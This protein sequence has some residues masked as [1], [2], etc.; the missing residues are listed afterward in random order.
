MTGTGSASGPPTHINIAGNL[1]TVTVPNTF[2]VGTEAKFLNLNAATYL[3]NT[4]VIVASASSTQFTAKFVHANDD[5]AIS[6]GSV[7]G[8]VCTN[9]QKWVRSCGTEVFDGTPGNEYAFRGPASS[10]LAHQDL[11]YDVNGEPVF[12][13]M[14]TQ[15]GDTKDYRALEITDLST[16]TPTA[17][18]SKRILMPCS[19]DYIGASCDSGVFV[20][21]DKDQG[22]ISLQGTSGPLKGY[23][24]LS[25][26]SMAGPAQG[27]DVLFPPKTTLGADVASA[28]T[29]TVA[30]VSMTQVGSGVAS[31][32]GFGTANAEVVNWMATTAAT[33]T[34]TFTKPHSASE[35]VSC[36]SCGS[37]GWAAMELL[38]IKID[39]TAVDNSNAVF[40]RIGRTHGIRDGN[41]N[42]EAHATVNRDFTQMIWGSSWDRDCQANSALD[43]YWMP[44]TSATPNF[45]L[46]TQI[47]GQGNITGC[48]GVQ[49]A[50]SS[51]SC[52]ITPASG[53]YL[54]GPP[55]S[56][57]GTLTQAGNAWSG[58]M[59]ANDCTVTATFNS[60]A[61]SLTTIK[62]VPS[63]ASI[64]A[65]ST[66]QFTATCTYMDS[67]NADCPGT[68]SWSS[69]NPAVA[70]IAATGLASGVAAGSTTI[71]VT[72]GSVS[73]S[74]VLTVT[75]PTLTRI[76]VTPATASIMAGTGTQQYAAAC[77]YSNNTNSD[78]T[79]AVSW[80]SSNLT[81]AKISAGGLVSAVG[82][83]RSTLKAT[84]DGI[85]GSAVLTVTPAP[86][87]LTSGS[88]TWI[89]GSN[90][91]PGPNKGH[92][93]IYSALGKPDA[94]D[95]PGGRAGSVG[96]TDADGN[97]WLFGGGGFDSAGVDGYL[98]DL[99]EFVP[100]VEEWAWIGGNSTVP[101]PNQGWPGI[102]GTLAVPGSG[103]FPGAREASVSWTDKSGNFWL[104]GG[105]GFDSAG[106]NGTLND[107]WEFTPATQEWVWMGG[108]STLPGANR[109]S[110]GVYGQLGVA[111]A[112]NIPGGRWGANSWTDT[113]GNF[114][115]FGGV[116]YDSKASSGLLNDLWEFN[117]AIRQWAWVGGSSTLGRSG[118]QADAYRPLDI[119]PPDN[120]PSGR[121]QAVTWTDNQG[122]LWLFGGKGYDST[123]TLDNL[124][125]LW[126]F[127]PSTREWAWMGG[128][129]TVG[130][131]GCGK[132]GVYG[133]EGQADS[134]NIP[135]GRTQ[136]VGWTDNNGNLWLLGGIGYDAT[137][138]YGMLNDLWEFLPSTH[139]WA[140]MGGS[141][142][143]PAVDKGQAGKY[144]QF[145][146]PNAGNTPGGRWGSNSWTDSRGMLWLFG[147]SGDDAS[148]TNGTL[149]DL[150]VYQPIP[151]NLPAATP[152]LSITSGTYHAA[153]TVTIADA[154]PGAKIYFTTDGTKPGTGS[155]VYSGPIQ[156]SSTMTIEA[157]AAAKGYMASEVASATYAITPAFSI[158]QSEGSATNVTIHPG[159]VAAYNLVVT[160]IGSSTLI[161][162]VT[163]A[164]TGLPRGWTA[165]FTPSTVG[166]GLAA[167]NVSFS[168]QTSTTSAL[169]VHARSHWT[170]VLCLTLMPFFGLR[171][172][173]SLA[174]QLSIK[175]RLLGGILSLVGL[176]IAVSGCSGYIV[177]DSSPSASSTTAYA[178]TVTAGSANIQHTTTL[179]VTVQ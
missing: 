136:A 53:W 121:S 5:Q 34:A 145:G 178:V 175:T 24:L 144:G 16:V 21:N 87:N 102:Y 74:A 169:N 158:A 152:T 57:C 131:A 97:L 109:G 14:S 3:N 8:M 52:K 94:G 119:P 134:V 128:R 26:F 82:A 93:G 2:R 88:W 49:V 173:R 55:A 59:P 141:S 42:C 11:G 84:S 147:G 171:R 12:V 15:R 114:W 58:T 64:S 122:N 63:T 22:H 27:S 150:W 164:V 17:I 162:P 6:S 83:G 179:T 124:N 138:A 135:G 47:N 126:E 111:N 44:L 165:T 174:A 103:N 108:S 160:P 140:W 116:G 77:G 41:Y 95:S 43:T 127:N 86:V 71:K 60:A 155:R 101:G 13:M 98:N 32:I 115:L 25:T 139:E 35:T 20:S 33:A 112:A 23:A 10:Y 159:G 151:G 176:S 80:S 1:L 163:L 37:T 125:D 118:S 148:G 50:D 9:D 132:P 69:S 70:S 51:F 157:I 81:A 146:V 45:I 68:V 48:Q 166:S 39:T 61:A 19:F 54:T 30:P 66:R 149:N 172:R 67:S 177:H 89:G 75:S 85:S 153:Q 65:G 105:I 170:I 72:S 110:S 99:W 130:C 100:S 106:N 4:F 96:W 123:G 18:T 38:A 7:S 79:R 133:T 113:S 62:V 56:T 36:L 29:A 107:L 143:V 90:T 73:S 154:T 46:S 76:T 31:V 40:W 142:T 28:G 156:V 120:V 104:F 91:V 137:A 78:C 92:S 161:A 167:T 168:I 129:D 117:S